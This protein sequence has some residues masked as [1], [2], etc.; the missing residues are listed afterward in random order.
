[1]KKLTLVLLVIVVAILSW[2]VIIKRNEEV[3]T[4]EWS[5]VEVGI[6]N[7]DPIYLKNC[8]WGMGSNSELIFVSNNTN[9]DLNSSKNSDYV[10]SSGAP[11]FYKL[12]SDTLIVFTTEIAIEPSVFESN[13]V[14]E[15]R[16]INNVEFIKMDKEF[17]QLGL[18]K[19]P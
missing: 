12:E 7:P 3:F 5:I 17:K 9:K 14:I 6:N 4:N 18:N 1:M 10:F 8:I 13:F 19:F 15:Q 16:K 2:I 11:I